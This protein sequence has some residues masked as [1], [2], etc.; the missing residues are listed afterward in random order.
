MSWN[1]S[2]YAV[3]LYD[4]DVGHVTTCAHSFHGLPTDVLISTAKLMA[5]ILTLTTY[6]NLGANATS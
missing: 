3:R 1:S 5:I 2:R 6:L 4:V